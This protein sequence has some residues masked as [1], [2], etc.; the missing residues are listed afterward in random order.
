MTSQPSPAPAPPQRPAVNRA[1]FRA[2]LAGLRG[3][4]VLLVAVY[5]VWIGRVS[6]GVDV[7]LLMSAFFLTASW[8][9]AEESGRPRGVL[10][11]WLRRLRGL[12]PA[13]ALVIVA[14]L[15][16]VLP[17][18]PATRWPELI[19]QA[20]ASLSYTQNLHLQQAS[21]DYYN[22]DHSSSSP[23][24]HFWSLSV[25]GQVFLL[26]PLLLAGAAL[27][28]RWASKRWPAWGFR[29]MALLLFA[30]VFVA[31]LAY[32]MYFTAADQGRAYFST[33]A[34][35]WEFALGSLLALSIDKLPAL[36]AWL[37]RMLGWGGLFALLFCGVILQ[38]QGQFPG[39]AALWPTLAAA[40]IIVAGNARVASPVDVGWWLSRR[41]ATWLGSI[42]YPLYL[43]HWPVLVLPLALWGQERPTALQ[44]GI[45]LVVAILLAWATHRWLERPLSTWAQAP[46]GAGTGRFAEAR[47]R[48]LA[49]ARR[50]SDAL[51]S[52]F[53]GLRLWRPLSPLVPSADRRQRAAVLASKR[54]RAAIKPL[55]VVGLC[56]LAVLPVLAWQGAIGRQ[57]KVASAQSPADNPGAA[58][59]APGYIDEANPSALTVPLAYDV[60]QDWAFVGRECDDGWA[61]DS[62]AAGLCQEGG[63]DQAE[64]TILVVGDS[65]AQQWTP[66]IDE[67][68]RKEDARW[69]LIVVHGCRFGSTDAAAERTECGEFTEAA[70]DYVLERSEQIEAV[71][72][73]ASRTYYAPAAGDETPGES[74]TVVPGYEQAVAGW[75]DA[76]IPVIGVRDTPRFGSDQA[77]CVATI[78]RSNAECGGEAAQLLAAVDPLLAL[79]SGPGKL[80]GFGGIDMSDVVCPDGQCVPVIG[81]VNVWMDNNHMTASF[82]RTAGEIFAERYSAALSGARAGLR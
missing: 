22:P 7:F 69:V 28:A 71:V 36:P 10:D 65:H 39:Y 63:N 70:Q 17:L 81:N 8:T 53:K 25:Q 50:R 56:S 2:D 9:K 12:L 60:K 55:A 32:S 30:A 58:T 21:V 24:Q 13:A 80:N 51:L 59:L 11:S 27:A 76:G 40:A 64:K 18:L 46:L 68:A 16:I 82:A 1:A 23:L 79:T 61:P 41:P 52:W 54:A 31:S 57:E 74:E 3:V 75:I 15:C 33:P 6:G 48:A 14:V 35:L 26:W 73:V 67:L 66:A 29:R 19:S 78:A 42:S 49:A 20:W 5:H 62:P 47:H 72:T 44:G 43:W 37:A 34:R 4:A 38:V 45:M 77:D